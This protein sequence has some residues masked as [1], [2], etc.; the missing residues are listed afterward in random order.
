MLL[1]IDD[2]SNLAV[3]D[4]EGLAVVKM[5]VRSVDRTSTRLYEVVPLEFAP[6]GFD[7]CLAIDETWI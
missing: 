7:E 6:R 3:D 1:A 4:A 5:H 2:E